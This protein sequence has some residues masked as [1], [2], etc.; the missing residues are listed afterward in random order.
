MRKALSL[1]SEVVRE[2][3]AKY[4]GNECPLG[5]QKSRYDGFGFE[6]EFWQRGADLGW[7]SFLVSEEHGGGSVGGNGLADLSLIAYEFG[8][9]GAPGP[10]I[11]SNLVAAALDDAQGDHQCRVLEGILNGTEIA[12]FCVEEGPQASVFQ[13]ALSIRQ[14]RDDLILCGVKRPVEAAAQ[15]DHLLVT[16]C[17]E[18]GLSQVLAP[19]GAP[20]LTVKP[21]DS[22]D[23]TRRFRLRGVQ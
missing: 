9:T 3:T 15:A 17:S 23:L 19:Q 8:R 20:G 21:M 10:L 4:L 2:T 1:D 18:F 6:R 16:G 14:D 5:S 12:A 22:V 11:A 7:T 13:S